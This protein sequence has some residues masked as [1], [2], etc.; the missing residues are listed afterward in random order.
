MI[1]LRVYSV[2]ANW[3]RVSMILEL[4]LYNRDGNTH[5]SAFLRHHHD[6]HLHLELHLVQEHKWK[7][8]LEEAKKKAKSEGDAWCQGMRN[9]LDTT[10]FW[11]FGRLAHDCSFLKGLLQ[12]CSYFCCLVEQIVK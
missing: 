6:R 10:W 4:D 8:Q 1:L 7:K 11:L 3:P 9:N 2:E 5:E 12:G